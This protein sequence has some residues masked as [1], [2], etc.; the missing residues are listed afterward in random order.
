[1]TSDAQKADGW[2]IPE[3]VT[4]YTDFVCYSFQV[5]NVSEY[6]TA[7]IGAVSQLA[8]WWN[9]E[10]SGAPDDRRAAQAAQYWRSLLFPINEC[11]EDTGCID[12]QPRTPIITWEPQNPFTEPDL[13]PAGYILPPFYEITPASIGDFIGYEIGDVLTDILRFPAGTGVIT[14]PESGWARF[15]ITVVGIGI[16]DI[17][18][19]NV[20][21][22]GYVLVTQDDDPLTAYFV[23]LNLDL[24]ALPPENNFVVGHERRFTTDGEHHID[25]TFVPRFNDETPAVFYGGGIRQITLCGFETMAFDIR[26]DPER[27]CIIQKTVDGETWV[28]AV[29]MTKC[30]VRV[31]INRGI[32]QWY[33]PVTDGWQDTDGGDEREDGDAPPPWP[34]PPVGENGDCLAAENIAAVYQTGLTEIHAGL[35]LGR[36]VVAI[37]AGLTGIM[38]VFIPAAIVSTVALAMTSIAVQAGVTAVEAMLT[39]VQD[40]KCS[41]YCNIQPDGSVTAENF[42]QIR[43][44]VATWASGIEL[45]IVRNWLD[46]FGSVGLTRQGSAAGITT[47][48]CIDCECDEEL[49]C[50]V[51]DFTTGSHGWE[52]ITD[53]ADW[54]Q[55][56]L[57]LD[58]GKG[59]TFT[60]SGVQ[61]FP[62]TGLSV[63]HSGI[64]INLNGTLEVPATGIGWRIRITRNT[65]NPCVSVQAQYH[66][67]NGDYWVTIDNTG[68]N[69]TTSTDVTYALGGTAGELIDRIYFMNASCGFTTDTYWVEEIEVIC[70][71]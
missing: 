17:K 33:D 46:G 8:K 70:G 7:F 43:A 19:L 6:R 63:A 26:Q 25:V 52:I 29:D 64:G 41:V 40:L 23:E 18:F 16:V 35:V 15:R 5:P 21:L 57:W 62:D 68:H 56:G 66:V 67:S 20:P 53:P 4:D 12:F 30:P 60:A 71:E 36:D 11:D 2:L 3:Q 24:V 54:N 14:E 58:Y 55:G 48:D 42:T 37:T 45:E 61:S 1:M 34:D 51:W 47:G 69:F 44:H 28:D 27:M 49:S 13:I 50:R 39:H 31:R 65:T 38:G 22:G 10:K 59:G 9:W 32:V